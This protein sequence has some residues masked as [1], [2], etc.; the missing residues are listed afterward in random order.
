MRDGSDLKDRAPEFHRELVE[1]HLELVGDQRRGE[2]RGPD[3]RLEDGGMASVPGLDRRR[4]ERRREDIFAPD[5]R[6]L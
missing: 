2:R 4:G 5:R 6:D 1:R 3:R